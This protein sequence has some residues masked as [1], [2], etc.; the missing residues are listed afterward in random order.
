[1]NK[2]I[3]SEMVTT[4]VKSGALIL[5][6]MTPEKADAIHAAIGVADQAACCRCRE[7]ARHLQQAA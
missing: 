5:E 7:K 1:M 3:H 2:I 6:Q 4:L